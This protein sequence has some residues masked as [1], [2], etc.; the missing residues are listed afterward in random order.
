ME[1]NR[2]EQ[3]RIHL[4]IAEYADDL[5]SIGERIFPGEQGAFW[6][7]RGS[8]GMTRIPN[9]CFVSPERAEIR[10][11]LWRGPA[12]VIDYIQEPDKSH[13]ANTSLYICND[14][15]YSLDKLIPAMR[16]NVHRGLRELK[17]VPVNSKE[18]LA[19]GIKAFCDTRLRNGLSD[20][21]PEE[22]K[23][24]FTLRSRCQ[25][26]VFLGAWRDDQLAAFLSITEVDDWA[27]IEGSF[28]QNVFLSSRPNDT[29]IFSAICKYLVEER[30]RVVTYGVSSIQ[31]E[32]SVAG[33]HAFKTKVGFQAKPVHRAFV[34]HPL[35]RPFSNE[36]MLL[37]IK[38]AL[39]FLPSNRILKKVRGMLALLLNGKRPSER[40]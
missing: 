33:L 15:S 20:G 10:R 24:R 28:S 30:R 19:N 22:F 25:G 36:L 8:G 2:I 31:E 40:I 12:L 14:Q 16:R 34:L 38:A 4:S 37:A 1:S 18:L 3:K 6:I 39:L 26:H 27:E 23:R 9:T 29:L 17:I 13:P 5:A 21:T 7:N 11:V 32:S 35:L